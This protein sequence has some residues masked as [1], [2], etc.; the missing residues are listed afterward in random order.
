MEEVLQRLVLSHPK[1]DTLTIAGRMW[2]EDKLESKRKKLCRKCNPDDHGAHFSSNEEAQL[3]EILNEGL[4]PEERAEKGGDAYVHHLCQ[5][6]GLVAH[7]NPETRTDEKAVS[8]SI[9]KLL[10][11]IGNLADLAGDNLPLTSAVTFALLKDSYEAIE[12]IYNMQDALK[13]SVRN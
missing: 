1:L 5:R 3:L 7:R 2:G 10:K 4:S 9:K 12:S 11:L 6:L 13:E 8:K